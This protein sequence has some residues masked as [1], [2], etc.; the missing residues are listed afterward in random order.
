M[1]SDPARNSNRFRRPQAAYAISLQYSMTIHSSDGSSVPAITLEISESGLSALVGAQL[2][3]GNKVTLEPVGGGMATAVVQRNL[4]KVY[5]FRF[6][7]ITAEQVQLI[8]K[9]CTRLPRFT[10]MTLSI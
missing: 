6:F 2:A 8:R 9:Q 10:C 3:L 4:G 1:C 5:G 7:E